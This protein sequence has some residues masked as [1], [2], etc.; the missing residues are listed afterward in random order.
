MLNVGLAGVE[1]GD[2]FLV[3]VEAGD[4]LADVG[5][6]QGQREA[7]VAAP[8]DSDFKIF[9]REKFRLAIRT[10]SQVLTLNR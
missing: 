2:L 4:A 9:P 7:H 5:E 6:A 10:H 8:D 3:G 1:L